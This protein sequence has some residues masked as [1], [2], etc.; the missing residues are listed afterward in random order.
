MGNFDSNRFRSSNQEWET[1][2]SIFAPLDKE[3]GFTLDVAASEDNH[4]CARYLT[5]DDNALL[6]SWA[7]ETCWLNPPYK[8]VGVWVKKA[9][10]ESRNGATVICLVQART[11]TNWWHNYCMKGEVR[12]IH[13]RPKFKGCK[14]GLP[15]PLAIVIFR[16]HLRM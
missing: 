2:N 1:P 3:F 6:K 15:Q 11:N 13:G 4:K 14:H 5:E 10:L 7:G 8:Q 12:F 16:K 9:F